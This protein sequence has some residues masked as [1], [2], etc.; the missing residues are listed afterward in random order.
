M[1]KSDVLII[2]AGVSGVGLACTLQTEC[3]GKTF[4][5]LERR[6]RLGG[7]WDLFNYPGVRS[8][9]DMLTYGFK[10]RP[11]QDAKV[12]A[13]GSTIWNYLADTAR[14]Y[15]IDKKIRYGLKITRADWSQADARWT[16]AALEEASGE[17]RLFTCSQLVMCTGYYNYDAGYRP[18]FPGIEN[19]GGQIVHPQ[20]WPQDLSLGGKKVVVIGS[21]ATAMTLVPALAKEA[22]QVTMLQRSPTY[23]LSVPSVDVLTQKLTRILPKRWAFAFARKRNTAVAR[24]LY[25]ACRKWPDKM[26]KFLLKQTAKH[27][28][29]SSTGIEHFTPNYMPWDQRLCIVP[30]ADLFTAIKSGKAS[31][32]T[33]QI[34]GFDGKT[35][36]LRS[37]KA[38]EADVLITATGLD[39]QVFGGTQ[40]FVDGE[41]YEPQ[42]HMLYKGVLLENL[43]N[44]A[45]I[46]GYTSLSWTLKSDL[47]AGYLCR[48]LEHMDAKG[49]NI[50][51][52]R[53][54]QNS[55]L[56]MSI[57][58]GLTSGYI[59]RANGVMP[60][61]GSQGPW[62]VSNHYPND[63]AML[64]EAPID[65]GV[66]SF[67]LQSSGR[68]A[69]KEPQAA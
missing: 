39:V 27:L 16:V 45:W 3:P 55:K 51:I 9:S 5:I 60:R 56:D 14:E 44:F 67:E 7:T 31:V 57:M 2:G 15:G 26:R 68:Q 30:D 37:G 12:L 46:V 62:A 64:L 54:T 11:W 50:F 47:L 20:H 58:G 42:T 10:F 65:D 29:G 36:K 66:L 59:S 4:V 53:D 8:D 6:Q 35:I 61:Q 28:E 49:K 13:D 18:S 33:D 41:L 1:Q 21:G 43:P 63:K 40:V 52:A 19:F 23:V 34:A 22:A 32:E 48:L 25:Q 17:T 69:R 38:L 24:W